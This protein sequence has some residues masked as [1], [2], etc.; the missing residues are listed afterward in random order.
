MISTKSFFSALLMVVVSFL[1]SGQSG[2]VAVFAQTPA[3][4]SGFVVTD[5]PTDA[6]FSEINPLKIGSTDC[7]EGVECVDRSEEFSKPAG[8]LSRVLF[9]AFP[10]AG[11]I[12]FVMLLWAGF[13]MLSG[14][15][16]KKSMDAGRQ[17][18]TTAIVGFL[19]LFVSYW[20][21]R[22]L[23]VIFGITIL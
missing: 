22:L 18:A 4:D 17:R 14:A 6:T 20:I 19:L 15:S 23:E 7:P 9:F 21:A 11:L 8:I 12:L 13:E 1:I 16:T 2:S 5:G 3:D 10:M